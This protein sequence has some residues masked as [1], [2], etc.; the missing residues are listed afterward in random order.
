MIGDEL[1]LVV[2]ILVVD[3]LDG[4]THKAAVRPKAVGVT[5]YLY[6]LLGGRTTGPVT[7]TPEQQ[8]RGAVTIQLVFDPYGH[9]R[10]PISDEELIERALA[11]RDFIGIPPKQA[12]LLTYDSG[13]AFRAEHAGMMPRL[14]PKPQRN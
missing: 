1:R 9:V 11:L 10:L 6:G 12:F 8:G 14:L 4:L 13:A 5:K 7:I 3:E 2:P